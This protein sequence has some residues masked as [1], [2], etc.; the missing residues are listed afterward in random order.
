MLQLSILPIANFPVVSLQDV[1]V[2]MSEGKDHGNVE[3]SMYPRW[4]VL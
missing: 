1:K 4:E 3:L 2:S